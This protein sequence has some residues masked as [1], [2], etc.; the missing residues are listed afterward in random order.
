LHALRSSWQCPSTTP[1]LRERR[2]MLIPT[3][4]RFN[5]PEGPVGL[6]RRSCPPNQVNR[7]SRR[8][9]RTL[10]STRNEPSLDQLSLHRRR[11]RRVDG[12][13]RG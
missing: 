5:D 2:F 12:I 4:G 13:V 8:E 1:L 7:R 11:S 10:R 3:D 6:L 9:A